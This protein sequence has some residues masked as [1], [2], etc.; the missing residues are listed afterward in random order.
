MAAKTENS[1]KNIIQEAVAKASVQNANF[2]LI[3]VTKYGSHVPVRVDADGTLR[4]TTIA[5]KEYS[6]SSIIKTAT[7]AL[8]KNAAEGTEV[9]FAEDSISHIFIHRP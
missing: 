1:V 4:T 2:V 9:V 8:S 7:D 6:I 3:V 5:E